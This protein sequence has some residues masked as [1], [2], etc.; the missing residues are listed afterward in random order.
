MISEIQI[1]GNKTQY[2]NIIGR[3]LSLKSALVV[4]KEELK[5]SKKN[6]QIRL[7]ELD[8]EN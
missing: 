4:I 3:S 2:C 8:D 5:N 6:Y 7:L 1:R